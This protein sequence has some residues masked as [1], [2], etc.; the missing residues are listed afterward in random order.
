MN[1]RKSFRVSLNLGGGGARGLA[2]LGVLRALQENKVKFDILIGVSMGAL[3]AAHYAYTLDIDEVENHIINHINKD[4]FKHSLL[5]TWRSDDHREMVSRSKKFLLKFNRLY[6]QTELYG[7]LLLAPG[8]LDDDDIQDVVYPLIP[9]VRFSDLKMP[10]ACVAVDL[11]S[12]KPKIFDQGPLRKPVLASLS[13]P[14]VFPPVQIEEGL[15]TDG[16]IVDRVGV[17]SAFILGVQK[18]I[19]VDVSN[20]F[21][22][23]KKIKTALDIM[24]RSEEISSIYRK[25]Y[26]LKQAA[27]VI[28][29]VHAPIHWAD[30]HNYESIIESGYNS[31]MEKMVEIKALV[32][33]QKSIIRF[34][35][36]G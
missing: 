3:I 8:I 14:L 12:G 4:V 35:T 15:Y 13:M 23:R 21:F 32:R 5:G 10:F 19:A 16:G 6:K 27:I 29:P 25:N 34:F 7:R 26:Q 31:T 11:E 33:S 18:I 22:E 2:H 17:D 1:S 36:K 30:Y 24:L 9:N 20:D 28:K